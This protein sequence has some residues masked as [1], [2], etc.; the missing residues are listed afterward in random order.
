MAGG[1]EAVGVADEGRAEAC[2]AAATTPGAEGS[3]GFD[4]TR[5]G[6]APGLDVRMQ[7]A[8]PEGTSMCCVAARYLSD[9]QK[10]LSL[11]PGVK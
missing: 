8:S 6:M 9:A 1:S 3:A 7:D 5:C 4:G 10:A 11:H 2:D